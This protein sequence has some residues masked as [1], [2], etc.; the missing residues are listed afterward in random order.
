MSPSA[1]TG[2]KTLTTGDSSESGSALRNFVIPNDPLNSASFNWASGSEVQLIFRFDYD[3]DNDSSTP[4]IP[5][6][7]LRLSDSTDITSLDLW[8]FT[9][10]AL[11]RQRGGATILNNV[12]NVNNR[13]QTVVEVD[14]PRDGSLLVQVMTLDGNI[15]KI[16]Q[17]GRVSSGLHYYKWDG[18]NNGGNAVA[19]GMYFIRIVGPDI[20]ETRKVMAVK[21]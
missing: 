8:S 11:Q 6:Y 20:D 7:C 12:I 9:L 1:N 5:K 10:V 4:A 17:K 16:L 3:D 18:T 2:T 21:E 13:E 15:V 14:V 19:R